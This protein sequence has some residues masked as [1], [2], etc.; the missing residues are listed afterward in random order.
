MAWLADGRGLV[1][2]AAEKGA[3]NRQIWRVA[4]PGGE[5]EAHHQRP[6]QLH[7]RQPVGRFA[8]AR[9][10]RVRRAV[11]AVRW[12]GRAAAS[13]RSLTSGLGRSDGLGGIAWTPDGRI[14]YAS[15]ASGNLDLWIMGDGR[16]AAAA[17]DG[18]PRHRRAARGLRPRAL[19]VLHVPPFRHAGDLARRPRRRGARAD[20]S[21][22]DRAE[23][24]VRARRGLG[25]LHDDLA[26]GPDH[27]LANAGGR[28]R[29]REA[30][31][32]PGAERGALAGRTVRGRFVLRPVHAAPEHRRRAAR[33]GRSAEGLPR[34]PE[35]AGRA[36]VLAGRQGAHL[37]GGAGRRRERLEPAARRR[38]AA[39][40]S[41]GSRPTASSR[42]RGP[43]TARASRFAR[44]TISTDVVLLAAK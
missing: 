6:G 30:P 16:L 26:R 24:R 8:R 29:S 9:H 22:R 19:P 5:S 3:T 7:G 25:H 36:G 18:R 11:F 42:S 10:D 39:R 35:V 38:R 34:L 33:H 2:T 17:A 37:R 44:G 40:R 4:Y 23:A 41:R 21:R 1:T 15:G 13:R 14:V 43:P 31:R 32:E 20:D 28:G 12:R 27:D